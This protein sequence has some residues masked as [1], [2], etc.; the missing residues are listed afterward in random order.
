MN[1]GGLTL[2]HQHTEESGCV[3]CVPHKTL[4]SFSSKNHVKL[5]TIQGSVNFSR[6]PERNPLSSQQMSQLTGAVQSSFSGYAYF[7]PWKTQT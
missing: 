6:A 3:G 1:L 7:N 4:P 2:F 5:T